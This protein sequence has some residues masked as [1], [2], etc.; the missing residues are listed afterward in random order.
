ML[1]EVLETI[2]QMI[3]N[4]GLEINDAFTAA[5][6]SML[7][8]VFIASFL[9]SAIP[10]LIKWVYKK[11]FKNT[12]NKSYK[13]KDCQCYEI[14]KQNPGFK[15]KRYIPKKLKSINDVEWCGKERMDT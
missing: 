1:V 3:K 8:F 12:D 2:T 5:F 15:D 14:C 10:D 13:C 6:M 9:G 11:F 7:F 4:D